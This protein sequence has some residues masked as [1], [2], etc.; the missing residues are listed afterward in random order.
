MDVNKSLAAALAGTEVEV[1]EPSIGQPIP[2]ANEIKTDDTATTT[3]QEPVGVDNTA[4]TDQVDNGSPDQTTTES[5]TEKTGAESTNET[6][7][8]SATT[9][10][11][12][13]TKQVEEPATEI[14]KEEEVEPIK[15]FEQLL[16]EKSGGKYKHWEDVQ[17]ELTPKNP[18][19][20]EQI[21]KFNELAKQ[22][23]KLDRNFWDIQGKDFT[24]MTDPEEILK[25][26]MRLSG[27]Y[28]GWSEQEL[29]LELNEKYKKKEWVDED[30]EPTVTKQLMSKRILR[31][32]EKAREALIKKQADLTIVTKPDPAV[33]QQRIADASK[34]QRDW[35]Y[36]VENELA[37]KT[38]KL[39]TII[40]EKTKATFDYE[41][42]Q[43]DHRKASEV[44]KK[45]NTNI[46]AFFDRYV[47][48]EG[49][50][51]Y[52][53][54][55]KTILRESSWQNQLT[56]ATQNARASGAEDEV[57]ESKNIDFKS[58]KDGTP[59]PIEENSLLNALRKAKGLT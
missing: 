46:G 30:E 56:I 4:N 39:S 17:T 58:T 55:Y 10:Q 9:E 45:L 44:M 13:E 52:P 34:Q 16:E 33:E 14:T 40:D 21:E 28:E 29:D 36:Y 3:T 24:S 25:E 51:N 26:E 5:N 53:A 6:S 49:A 18:F 59:A 43:D 2:A 19:A 27:D 38:P 42:S 48:A 22:G 41:V 47:N 20:N 12:T 11:A 37:A 15:S 7:T 8:E 32:S 54:I 23:V 31:D 1:V 57:K 35:D 50:I